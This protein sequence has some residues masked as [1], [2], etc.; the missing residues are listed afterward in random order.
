MEIL[1]GKDVPTQERQMGDLLDKDL[2]G[3][4]WL[5]KLAWFN[6]VFYLIAILFWKL[7]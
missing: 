1:F 7:I 2:I 4:S 6:A 5:L 3:L